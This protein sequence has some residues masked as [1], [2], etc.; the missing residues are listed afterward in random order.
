MYVP[1]VRMHACMYVC[2]TPCRATVPDVREGDARR[3][4]SYDTPDFVQHKLCYLAECVF[5]N[6]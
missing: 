5:K 1:G 2:T 6:L 4:N 3:N